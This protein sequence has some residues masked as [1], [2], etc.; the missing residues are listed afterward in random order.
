M[1]ERYTAAYLNG[2]PAQ[3]RAEGVWLYIDRVIAKV[4]DAAT[5]GKTGFIYEEKHWNYYTQGVGHRYPVKPTMEELTIALQD[6]FPDSKVELQDF[7]VD[8]QPGIREQRRQIVI[9]WTPPGKSQDI[10]VLNTNAIPA[11]TLKL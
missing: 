5:N 9:D 8:V 10:E 7:W 3:K 2:L 4:L 1:R 6:W 11:Q